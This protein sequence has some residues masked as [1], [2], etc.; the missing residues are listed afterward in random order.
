M[1]KKRITW[2]DKMQVW[3]E[4]ATEQE[5]R[6]AMASVDVWCRVRKFGFRVAVVPAPNPVEK[7]E[8]R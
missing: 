6:D 2:T 1:S 3:L 5:I 7:K 8:S 4:T